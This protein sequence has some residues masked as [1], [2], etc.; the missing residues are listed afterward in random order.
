MVYAVLDWFNNHPDV[1]GISIASSANSL[2]LINKNIYRLQI[3]DS[4]LLD[5]INVPLQ[6]TINSNGIIFYVY[7]ENEVAT[8]E[9]LIK[10]QNRYGKS[11]IIQYPVKIDKSNITQTDLINFFINTYNATTVDSIVLYLISGERQTYLNNFNGPLYVPS[12]QYDIDGSFPIIDSSNTNLNGLY[13]PLTLKNITSSELWSSGL[14]YLGYVD[15][16]PNTLN[17]I[18]M[19]T[20]F[21][22]NY[23]VLSLASYNSCLQF[24][25]FNDTIYGSVAIFVYQDGTFVSQSIYCNDPLYGEIYFTKIVN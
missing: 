15:F 23:D 16:S 8:E 24:N 5:A 6:N 19:A 2:G 14:Q 18:Y 12:S 25:E 4:Y 9:V 13:Y 22:N 3:E 7:S 17:A 20:L 1:I 21:S 11:N 10:L